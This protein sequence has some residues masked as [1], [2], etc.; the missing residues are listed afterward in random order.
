MCNRLVSPFRVRTT[1]HSSTDGDTHN[2]SVTPPIVESEN[3][4]P[5]PLRRF[6]NERVG[7]ELMVHG[8]AW[9]NRTVVK[10]VILDKLSVRWRVGEDSSAAVSVYDVKLTAVGFST[11]SGGR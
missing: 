3:L 6:G 10:M 4:F 1:E 8:E 2:E 9:R 11:R 7:G 5:T